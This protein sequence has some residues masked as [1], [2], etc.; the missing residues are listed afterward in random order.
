M[1]KRKVHQQLKVSEN[2]VVSVD[3][4]AARDTMPFCGT[5]GC[6]NTSMP[7]KKG[8]RKPK[9]ANGKYVCVVCNEAHMDTI[10]HLRNMGE[11]LGMNAVGNYINVNKDKNSVFDLAEDVNSL[12]EFIE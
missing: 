5:K 12:T 8:S 2:G 11:D 4:I 3:D 7:E 10:R 6:K 9:K 1:A